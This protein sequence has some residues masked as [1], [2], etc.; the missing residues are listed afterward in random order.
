MDRILGQI[1]E[2]LS[3]SLSTA[4][5]DNRAAEV[6]LL[7]ATPGSTLLLLAPYPSHTSPAIWQDR[8]MHRASAGAMLG[9]LAS[10]R[11]S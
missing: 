3:I 4:V 1:A 7:P 2:T 11:D 5:T 6:P 10:V 8:A 9:S